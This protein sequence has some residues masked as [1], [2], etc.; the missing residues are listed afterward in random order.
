MD[1]VIPSLLL[2]DIYILLCQLP[3]VLFNTTQ[4]QGLNKYRY[5]I[6]FTWD[7]VMYQYYVLYGYVYTFFV[8]LLYH[9]DIRYILIQV[10]S[11]RVRIYYLLTYSSIKYLYTT[12][13]KCESYVLGTVPTTL[14]AMSTCKQIESD[15]KEHS[16]Q[17]QQQQ[18]HLPLYIQQGQ[19][20]GTIPALH[21]HQI[22][23]TAFVPFHHS[24]F[25][26]PV[27]RLFFSLVPGSKRIRQQSDWHVFSVINWWVEQWLFVRDARSD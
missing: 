9:R 26:S 14:G 12:H 16:I 17:Q 6:L 1:L 10:V 23:L 11:V 7:I 8:L 19:Y 13:L 4:D 27:K 2:G 5:P 22:L 24:I 21:E 25:P 15:D 18:K 3:A 20:L